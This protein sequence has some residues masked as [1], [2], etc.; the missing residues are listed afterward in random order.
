MKK[1]GDLLASLICVTFLVAGCASTS[2]TADDTD[3]GTTA[4]DGSSGAD[5][6]DGATDTSASDG[7]D[8][9]DGTSGASGSTSADGSSG[10]DGATTA[11]TASPATLQDSAVSKGCDPNQQF[12]NGDANLTMEL[13]LT[14]PVFDVSDNVM[15]FYAAQGSGEYNGVLVTAGQ[16]VMFPALAQG[17][18]VQVT[19]DHV[20][21]YCMTQLRASSVT[22]L[23]EGT[24]VEPTAITGDALA[25]EVSA[26]PLEGVLVKLENV[27]VEAT[28][29][30]DFTVTG[31]TLVTGSA[32]AAGFYPNVGDE[33][34]S[35]V[36]VVDFSF[37]KHKVQIRSAA[38]VESIAG[39]ATETTISAI[40]QDASSETCTNE[41]GNLPP[42]Q[43]NIAFDGIIV[44]PIESVSDNLS[45]AYVSTDMPG[46]WSGVFIVWLKSK[47]YAPTIGDRVRLTGDIKEF[48]CSTQL[49]TAA[50]EIVESGNA[51]EPFVVSGVNFDESHEGSYVKLTDPTVSSIEN[52]ESYGEIEVTGAADT[53]YI[54]AFSDYGLSWSPLVG[55]SVA[56]IVGAVKYS[57]GAYKLVPFGD[58]FITE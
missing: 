45:G 32:F 6:S 19:G 54:I 7:Q 29:Q 38:D 2:G 21:F 1:S 4:T 56:S 41:E 49:D 16:G 25:S 57:F 10:T 27:T 33:I 20:E 17:D 53:T 31:G 52:L 39:E 36:G 9:N 51:P 42:T 48:Y 13:V 44:S 34:S 3:A 23:G 24:A 58:S 35:L 15:G 47:D 26:E 14:T 43:A 55:D 8:G 5:G 37:N 40:Q 12:S 30:Y 18:S 46:A 50:L 28:S 11:G 22:R